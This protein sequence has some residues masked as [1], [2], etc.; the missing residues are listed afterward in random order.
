MSDP[1]QL[2]DGVMRMYEDGCGHFAESNED[3]ILINTPRDIL[4]FTFIEGHGK[5]R[6]MWLSDRDEQFYIRPYADG[7]PYRRDIVIEMDEAQAKE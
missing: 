4:P 5:V 6:E 2:P 3:V 7:R 1:D